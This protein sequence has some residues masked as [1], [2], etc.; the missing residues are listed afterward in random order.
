MVGINKNICDMT[1]NELNKY[2]L[3]NTNYKIPLLEDVL[4]LINNK[5]LINI[6]IKSNNCR[7]CNILNK[8]LE[9]YNNFIIQ[10]FNT[11]IVKWYKKIKKNI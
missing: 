11:K 8:K 10:S 1:Y 5:V 7:I 4:K 6:E 3:L 2:Y 9:N